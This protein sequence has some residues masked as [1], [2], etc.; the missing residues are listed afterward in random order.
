MTKQAPYGAWP[1]K[2]TTDAIL[3]SSIN[4]SDAVVTPAGAI[5][6]L[7]GRASEKGRNA[8]VLRDSGGKAQEV[9]PDQTYNARTR[10]QEYGGA[11]FAAVGDKII[12]SDFAGPLY[13][14]APGG[15]TPEQISPSESIRASCETKFAILTLPFVSQKVTFIDSPTSPPIL[16]IPIYSYRSWRTTPI[17]LPPTSPL[18]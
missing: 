3:A 1:S 5:A 8:I 7:E 16:S 4:I 10:V 6:W 2:L 15:T 14:V 17:P 12:F 18:R 9:I 11:S 13:S